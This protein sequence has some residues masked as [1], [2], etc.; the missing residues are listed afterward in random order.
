MPSFIIALIALLSLFFLSL[1]TG[2][3]R[4]LHRRDARKTLQGLGLLFFYGPV[5]KVLYPK[6]EV[7]GLL[8]SAVAARNIFRTLF[9]GSAT[10]W[11]Y[12]KGFFHVYWPLATLG[13]CFFLL[14]FLIFTE[15][16]P[17]FI[18]SQSATYSLSL[19]APLCSPFLL[20]TLPLF[21]PL[22]K[23][24]EALWQT[25]DFD[26]LNEP[27]REMKQE[28]FEIVQGSEIAPTLSTDDRKLLESAVR[29][30]QRIAREVMVP[31]IDIFSING[32][33]S[34]REAAKLLHEQ[35]YSRVPVYKETVDNLVG[36]LMHKDLLTKYMEAMG[37]KKEDLLDA[38][39]ET[40]VKPVF[41]IPETKPIS[42]LLQDFRKRQV[43]LAVVVDEYGG[44]EGLVTMEDTL[45]EI[46]GEIEDEYDDEEDRFISLSDQNWVIDARMTIIDAEQ[47]LGIHIPQSSEYDSIGGYIFH[48]TGSIPSKGFIL[49]LDNLEIEVIRSNE[50]RIEKVRI[51]KT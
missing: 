27:M 42:T 1:L 30:Q 13:I 25:I 8:F 32:A 44:T 33:T 48:K 38:P 45:E 50:R 19:A 51:R 14:T 24:A 16:L 20:L 18:T 28:I 35:G 26:S 47:Q 5:L 15:Y 3:L 29:F 17:R 7:D 11:L 46:V 41:Y 36:I 22:M 40:I 12:E 6:E 23:I 21:A 9:A 2:A 37:S 34:I 10:L 49:Q 31:R 39:V 43:H 4:R